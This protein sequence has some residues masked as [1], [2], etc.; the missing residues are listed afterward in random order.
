M[1]ASRSKKVQWRFREE[2][3]RE[4]EWMKNLSRD[5]RR[6]CNVFLKGRGLD[7]ERSPAIESQA[8]RDERNKRRIASYGRSKVRN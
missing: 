2:E 4:D 7:Y 6:A 5:V 8:A 3:C 1:S